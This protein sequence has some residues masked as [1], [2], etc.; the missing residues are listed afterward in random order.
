MGQRTYG[1]ITFETSNEDK[2]FFPS[3]KGKGITKGDLIDYYERIADVML[4]HLAHRPLVM[5]RFPDGMDGED[6]YHKQA[7]DY[8]PDWITTVKVKKEGGKQDLV[9]CDKKATLAYLGQQA[10]ITPHIW[11]SKIDKLHHPDKLMVDLDPSTGDFEQ[12]RN[13]ARKVRD[14]FKELNLDPMIKTTGSRGLHIVVFLDQAAD[15]D[16]VRQF[17]QDMAEVLA[18]RYPDE[19]TTA[20]LKKDRGDRVYIDVAR[21]SYAQTA[22]APYG[23]RA[24]KDA[25]VAAPI[26]WDELDDTSLHAQSYNLGN[27]FRRLSQ[28][29]DP[30]KNV[31]RLGKSLKRPRSTLDKLFEDSHT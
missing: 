26:D 12:V 8:F 5:H 24:R 23:V 19:L 18:R 2:V 1:N 9:V 27:I 6:F 15:F 30:W 7:P 16:T 31:A 25:P 21:N 22:V 29:D 11:L 3:S 10:C 28:K 14:I 20:R 13:A 17:G 4:P